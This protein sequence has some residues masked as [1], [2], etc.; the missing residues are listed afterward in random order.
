MAY[1]VRVWDAPTRLFHWLLVAS[2]I[3]LVITA[4]IGGAAMDWHFRLGYVVLAL[5]AFRLIWGFMGGRW[6]RFATFLY[7]PRQVLAYLQGRGAQEHLVGHN[8][9]GALSVFALLTFLALQVGSGLMSDDEIAA[10]GPLTRFVSGTWV[11]NATFYHK[12]VGKLILIS[13]VLL[14]VLAIAFYFFKKRDN[15]V[16]PM[17]NG[18]KAL[19][20]PAESANDSKV[21]RVKAAGI[22]LVCAA[23]VGALLAWLN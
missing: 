4:E 16:K 3:A 22:A 23:L 1:V 17:I 11:S 15:L 6:S 12:E 18:D 14:H 21:Q 2:V 7:S 8:P 9:M 10:A 20:F 5:L 19:E 13:L